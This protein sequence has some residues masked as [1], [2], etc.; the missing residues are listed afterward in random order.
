MICLDTMLLIWG[1]QGVA[2]PEQQSMTDQTRRFLR[3]LSENQETVILPTPVVTEY[4]QAFPA[5]ARIEQLEFLVETF[6]IVPFDLPAAGLAAELAYEARNVARPATV[7]RQ[8]MKADTQI[9]ATA[10]VHGA[11]EIVT[12]EQELFGRLAGGRIKVS[13]VPS[14]PEQTFLDL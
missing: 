4:I 7:T 1:V 5:P 8:S 3:A 13:A 9:L 12:D 10:I 6:Q 14:I 11:R 2:R